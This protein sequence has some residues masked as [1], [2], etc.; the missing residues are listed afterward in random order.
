M[1]RD[2]SRYITLLRIISNL[3]N[4]PAGNCCRRGIEALQEC[5]C[6]VLHSRL[7]SV[8]LCSDL[9]LIKNDVYSL[10]GRQ[11]ILNDN[12]MFGS[13]P[14]IGFGDHFKRVNISI[15]IEG[16]YNEHSIYDTRS[17]PL[18][19]VSRRNRRSSTCIILPS[20]VTYTLA[21]E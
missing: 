13:V 15:S 17:R 1:D 16:Y 5:S 6:D 3:N 2:I 9:L 8:K 14:V 18:K 20:L 11:F 21:E 7:I 12:R 4:E 19:C 10:K